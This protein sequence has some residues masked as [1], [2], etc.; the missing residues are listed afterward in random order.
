[1][2]ARAGVRTPLRSFTSLG[3]PNAQRGRVPAAVQ[4]S[5]CTRV[6]M[7][8]LHGLCTHQLPFQNRHCYHQAISTALEMTLCSPGPCSKAGRRTP[9]H[10]WKA[11][12]LQTEE[13][14]RSSGNKERTQLLPRRFYQTV[15]SHEA[16]F[17]GAS[18]GARLCYTPGHE[19]SPLRELRQQTRSPQPLRAGRGPSGSSPPQTPAI[20]P[21]HWAYCDGMCKAMKRKYPHGMLQSKHEILRKLMLTACITSPSAGATP[22]CLPPKR[23]RAPLL[24]QEKRIPQNSCFFCLPLRFSFYKHKTLSHATTFAHKSKQYSGGEYWRKLPAGSAHLIYMTTRQRIC[25]ADKGA[26][27]RTDTV[28]TTSVQH[29]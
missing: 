10:R 28:I 11:T 18:Y 15:S 14:P 23:R 1:M 2:A 7:P 9:H 27:S 16:P 25:Y 26:Q 4:K 24:W 29:L 13:L 12:A 17:L 5:V 19:R 20:Q 22:A 21:I 8:Q 6:Y 3:I